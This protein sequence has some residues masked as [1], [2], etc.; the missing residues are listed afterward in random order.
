LSSLLQKKH[1]VYFLSLG[2]NQHDCLANAESSTKFVGR[3]FQTWVLKERDPWTFEAPSLPTEPGVYKT[4]SNK[5]KVFSKLWV[6]LKLFNAQLFK[7]F[8]FCVFV[9]H[10]EYY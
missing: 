6:A 1:I 8:G 10:R 9:F 2:F 5:T 3:E 7:F 4:N